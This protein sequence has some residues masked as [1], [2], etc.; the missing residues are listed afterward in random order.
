MPRAESQTQ[1]SDGR[2]PV[3][4]RGDRSVAREPGQ[5]ADACRSPGPPEAPRV[6]EGPGGV[7]AAARGRVFPAKKHLKKMRNIPY[8]VETDVLSYRAVDPGCRSMPAGGL[9]WPLPTVKAEGR[10]GCNRNRRSQA[11]TLHPGGEAAGSRFRA[12]RPIF[13]GVRSQESGVCW[14]AWG[15][16]DKRSGVRRR[17]YANDV[18][19]ARQPHRATA[20]TQSRK[21]KHETRRGPPSH[22][23]GSPGGPCRALE[24]R[25]VCGDPGVPVG[26]GGDGT[27]QSRA[28]LFRRRCGSVMLRA[29]ISARC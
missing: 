22:L 11:G 17:A 23:P 4:C 7:L 10:H 2:Q 6:L 18:T 15:V 16:S 29:G 27:S 28:C 8:W 20:I 26:S 13:S 24:A 19:T 25:R 5:Q 3:D 21:R 9:R 1:A 12:G 14:R